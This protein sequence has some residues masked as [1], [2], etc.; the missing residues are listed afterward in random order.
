MSNKKKGVV[1]RLFAWK[2]NLLKQPMTWFI[3]IDGVL[4]GGIVVY[5]YLEGWPF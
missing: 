2:W 4:A 3:W 1:G 5:L